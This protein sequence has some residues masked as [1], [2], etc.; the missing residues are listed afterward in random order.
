[1][2]W[3]RSSA[4]G[5]EVRDGAF[6][7][8]VRYNVCA[9]GRRNQVLAGYEGPVHSGTWKIGTC[10]HTEGAMTCFA[11]LKSIQDLEFRV[12][13]QATPAFRVSQSRRVKLESS[14]P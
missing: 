13:L 10:V 1:M 3:K 12:V 8:Q 11:N 6:G 2:R 9:G 4:R 5:A 14:R 7:E